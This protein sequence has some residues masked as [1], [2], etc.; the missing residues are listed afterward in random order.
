MKVV[1]KCNEDCFSIFVTHNFT[2]W[3]EYAKE[4]QTRGETSILQGSVVTFSGLVSKQVRKCRICNKRE[5]Y[6]EDI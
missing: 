2:P 6:S 4:K 3:R 1:K 5:Y